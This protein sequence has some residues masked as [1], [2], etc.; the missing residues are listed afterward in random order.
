M[1]DEWEA[2]FEAWVANG[3]MPDSSSFEEAYCGKWDSFEDYAYD[4]AEEI[5][6]L[7]GVPEDIRPYFAVDR[8]ARDLLLGGDYWTAD[9]DGGVYVF[10]SF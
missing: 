7:A 3:N 6:L 9:G 1:S 2:A 5:G 10:R 4:L 8:W